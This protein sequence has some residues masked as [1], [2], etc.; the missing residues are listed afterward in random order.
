MKK[1][2]EGSKEQGV[3]QLCNMFRVEM[4]E[5]FHEANKFR[6]KESR[7]TAKGHEHVVRPCGSKA[8]KKYNRYAWEKKYG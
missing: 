3:I 2:Y 7:P 8:L 5:F 4:S 1:W 6:H